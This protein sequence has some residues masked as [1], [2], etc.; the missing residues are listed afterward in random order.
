MV[1]RTESGDEEIFETSSLF[2]LD[3]WVEI[4]LIGFDEFCW[5]GVEVFDW[6]WKMLTWNQKASKRFMTASAS[7]NGG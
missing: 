1:W 3:N 7:I 5:I 4:I 2:D 6:F